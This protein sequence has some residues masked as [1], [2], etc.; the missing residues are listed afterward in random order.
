MLYQIN[1][2]RGRDISATEYV[3]AD[4]FDEAWC[5]GDCMAVYPEHVADVFPCSVF[6]DYGVNPSEV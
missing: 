1:F 2:A 6:N 5:K 4:S 3:H